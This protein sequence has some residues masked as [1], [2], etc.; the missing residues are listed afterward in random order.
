[1]PTSRTPD[2][3]CDS[4]ALKVGWCLHRLV[5]HVHLLMGLTQLVHHV[6]ILV[7]PLKV[8]DHPP[9]VLLGVASLAPGDGLLTEQCA[10]HPSSR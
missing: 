5:T 8:I 10:Q 3:Q 9:I 1:M 2:A 6:Q 7:D 4:L